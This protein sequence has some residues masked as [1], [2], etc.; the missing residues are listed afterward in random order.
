MGGGYS[1]DHLLHRRS[2]A[3]GQGRD[4]QRD[5]LHGPRRGLSESGLIPHDARPSHPLR[6]RAEARQPGTR[7]HS[8]TPATAT[9]SPLAATITPRGRNVDNKV[10][11][12]NNLIYAMTGGQTAPTTPGQANTATNLYGAFE[13][14][15]NLQQLAEAAGA[16]YVARCTTYHVKQLARSM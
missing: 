6:H 11:C 14:A 5:R 12:V 8:S 13:P 3:T 2:Q 1:I 16:V 15:F 4:R 9:C 7:R 10:I